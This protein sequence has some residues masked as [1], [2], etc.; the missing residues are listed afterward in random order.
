MKEKEAY[1]DNLE[2]ILSFLRDK[3]N[4]GRHILRITDVQEYSGFS[5]EY[6]K[7]HFLDGGKSI[8]AETFARALS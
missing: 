4:D 1:R 2:A 6:V 3:Y 5:Y 8:S 7:K